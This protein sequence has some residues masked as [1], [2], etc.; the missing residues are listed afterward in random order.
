MSHQ[1]Q[2]QQQ[3]L[4][5]GGGGGSSGGGSTSG[6]LDIPLSLFECLQLLNKV[7]EQDDNNNNNNNNNSNS[8]VSSDWILLGAMNGVR[9]W[10]SNHLSS[11][12]INTLG[13]E[14]SS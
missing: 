1:Q 12:G 13:V 4:D 10:K 7:R 14:F 6:I 9:S 3:Q 5:G 2:Q 8:G 11:K